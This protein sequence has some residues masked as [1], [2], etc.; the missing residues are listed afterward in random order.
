MA[1]ADPRRPEAP[2]AVAAPPAAAPGFGY[3][4]WIQRTIGRL[5]ISGYVA[6]VAA[7]LLILL[8]LFGPLLVSADPG[9]SDLGLA[10]AGPSG[11][12]PLGADASG[13]DILARL[14]TGARISLIGPALLVLI[15]S[16]LGST[17]AVSA[18]WRGG[19]W[20][21]LVSR[22][23]D[24]MLAFP[25]IVLALLVIAMVGTGLSAAISGLAAVYTAYVV[26]IVRSA[27]IRERSLPYIEA[28]EAQGQSGLRVCLHHL[29]PNLRP[30]IFGQAAALFGY[31]M[32]D[33]AGLS[34]IGVGVQP[35]DIDWGLMVA[36]GKTAVTRGHP[37]E[38]LYAGGLIVIA[39]ISFNVLV[40]RLTVGRK[41]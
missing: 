26:R 8:A 1:E 40:D 4:D 30:L 39:V 29:L 17:L 32:I 18:A 21:A 20:D 13:R 23:T 33:I 36:E 7:G 37:Q 16:T 14:L 15:A 31:A 34:F 27:A 11:A 35:P 2:A 9:K 22:I 3:L 24:I 10:F 25:P 5:G 6:G 12:H 19:W 28:C 41:G 38:A